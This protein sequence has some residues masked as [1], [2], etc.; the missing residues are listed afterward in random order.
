MEQVNKSRYTKGDND[1]RRK[2]TNGTNLPN[3]TKP[4]ITDQISCHSDEM[5]Q[6]RRMTASKKPSIQ[7]KIPS[8][9][10]GRVENDHG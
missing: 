7:R 9:E 2:E 1:H 4:C 6:S 3:D 5:V 8:S 10:E